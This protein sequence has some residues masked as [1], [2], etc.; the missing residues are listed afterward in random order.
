MWIALVLTALTVVAVAILGPL[1]GALLLRVVRTPKVADT[2][3]LDTKHSRRKRVTWAAD[4]H[5]VQTRMQP[6][7]IV[8]KGARNCAVTQRNYVIQ[9]T[10]M[11]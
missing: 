11:S 9:E 4:L 3:E 10:T 7:Q 8:H 5:Q 6:T 2:G 1:L